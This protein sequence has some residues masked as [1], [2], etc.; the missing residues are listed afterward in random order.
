MDKQSLKKHHFWILLGLAVV[1]VPIA[2]SGAMFG[3]GGQAQ[4]RTKKI[5]DELKSLNGQQVKPDDYRDQLEAQKTELQAQKTRVWKE[6]YKAQE[7][8][9]HWP[10]ALSHLDALYF[11]D[12]INDQDRANFMRTEVYLAEYNKL[13]DVIAPTEFP[14]RNWQSV[15]RYVPEFRTLPTPE[16]VW[17]ALEDLCVQREVLQDIHAVNQMLAEFLPVPLPPKAPAKPQGN[18]V[19]EKKR[20]DEE[21]ARYLKSKEVYDAAKRKVDEELKA[22]LKPTAAE[23]AFRFISPYWQLDIVVGR[24]P[25]GRAGELDFRGRLTNTSPRRQN[26][27]EIGFRVWLTNPDRPNAEYVVLPIQAEYL[28]AG[29]SV[30]FSETRV[31]QADPNLTVYKVEQKLD[32]R[33]VP[34]KRLDQL[35]LDYP[36]NRF[37]GKT[38]IGSAVSEEEKKKLAAAT[39]ANPAPTGG[40]DLR[41]GGPFGGAGPTNSQDFTPNGIPRNRYLERTDQVRRMPVALVMI[42][43]EAH[44]QDVLRALANSRLRFQNTQFHYERFR[45]IINLEEPAPIVGADAQTPQTAP[46]GGETERRVGGARRPGGD[47][48]DVAASVGAGGKGGRSFGG[49]R[50]RGGTP[51]TR[52]GPGPGP[53][54]GMPSLGDSGSTSEENNN[55]V[56]LTVYGLISLYERFPPKPSADANAANATNP[57]APPPAGSTAPPPPPPPNAPFVPPMN[58][59][60]G[61]PPPPPAGPNPTATPPTK[62]PGSP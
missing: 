33:Y 23:R 24:K 11:G 36:S 4:E 55:L 43:D 5:D 62:P 3:V 41:G 26:V 38:L 8:L 56:E 39:P 1:L 25:G 54:G 34:V 58:P 10:R 37:A 35:K 53:F 31:G 16:E 21:W 44:V 61:L 52:P 60:G 12:P 57:A 18:A 40:G 45:G 59:A 29:A 51:R 28:A 19:E 20:Y 47:S 6:A 13:P 49:E 2:C 32:S 50:E 46:G 42:V 48:G 30:D 27:A 14:D 9:V 17:L 15:L 7:G 22:T